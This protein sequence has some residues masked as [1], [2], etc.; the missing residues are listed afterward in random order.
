MEA[1]RKYGAI[2]GIY[3]ELRREIGRG[4]QFRGE[5]TGKRIEEFPACDEIGD[6]RKYPPR[7]ILLNWGSGGISM[8]RNG[9]ILRKEY[10]TEKNL[11]RGKK[12]RI[13]V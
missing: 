8:G 1:E 12:N 9:V 5:N 7:P 13:A 3:R 11:I 6:I 2:A 4:I 10:D